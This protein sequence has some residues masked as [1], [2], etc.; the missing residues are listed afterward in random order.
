VMS[1][2][3]VKTLDSAFAVLPAVVERARQRVTLNT[4]PSPQDFNS[5]ADSVK[6]TIT[7]GINSGDNILKANGVGD[8]TLNFSPI[9][10]RVNDTTQTTYTM[11]NYYAY[12]DGSAEFGAGLNQPGSELAY[13]FTMITHK[14]D[15]IVA[16]DMYFPDFGDESSQDITLII[17]QDSMVNDTI[18]PGH[19]L[20]SEIVSL[21]RSAL[22][23][24]WRHILNVNTIGVR[25]TF[26]LGWQQTSSA[27]IALGLDKSND[28]G[29][30]MYYNTNGYWIQNN[31]AD[32]DDYI[33]GSLMIRPVFG[34][35]GI[36][37]GLPPEPVV[38]EA[39]PNPNAGSFYL[40]VKPDLMEIF[41]LT[42]RRIGFTQ[43]GTKD[44]ATVEMANSP[45]GIYILKAFI[46]G[47]SFNR[48]IMVHP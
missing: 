11:A 33:A 17:R 1:S 23:N 6:F 12:D 16:V 19:I 4:I 22:N 10:F 36:V 28:T 48:K 47:K 5:S 34:K 32:S 37:A 29:T 8:Y 44:Q 38:F 14:P 3:K 20:Y 35:G 27:V 24:F 40:T 25:D 26:F 13:Y 45:P 18:Y 46:G 39:F 9:D 42:G 15:T 7:A 21:Q 31:P 41:D 30:R 2:A 43:G